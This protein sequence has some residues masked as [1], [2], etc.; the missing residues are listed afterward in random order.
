[1]SKSPEEARWTGRS[2]LHIRL[3]PGGAV[4][5]HEV[6]LSVANTDESK[7]W[8][9]SGP[10][11]RYPPHLL[12]S[13]LQKC[14]RRGLREKAC[15]TALE[16]ARS[17]LDVLLRRL[18]VI[19]VED[20]D[21]PLPWITSLIFFI[22]ATNDGYRLTEGD[23]GI[24]LGIVAGAARCEK[25]PV[26]TFARQI[27]LED[28]PKDDRLSLL[29]RAAYGGM[30]C[31]VDMLMRR[32][33]FAE[34]EREDFRVDPVPPATVDD[35]QPSEW[36]LAGVDFHCS[37]ITSRV[38]KGLS[39][40]GRHVSDDEIKAWMWTHRSSINFRTARTRPELPAWATA[41]EETADRAA[42]DII[43]A[44]YTAID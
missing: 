25:K 11:Q 38:V 2:K 33:A 32:A 44:A 26:E 14:V 40:S 18:P 36:C 31:D 22:L 43:R 3:C 9:R 39:N 8:R 10:R 15:Q 1:M 12:Q 30:K 4:S 35:L 23:V 6:S 20:L 34:E 17:S 28:F 29:A 42:R 21:A 27:Y 37:N 7:E 13:H 41:A 16:L 24:V 19:L 5:K